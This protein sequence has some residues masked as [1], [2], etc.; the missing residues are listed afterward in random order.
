[1]TYQRTSGPFPLSAVKTDKDQ[2]TII[3]RQGN[4]Y[5]KTFDPSAALLI[6][7]APDLL[8]ACACALADLEG[9]IPAID[10]DGARK[11]P[12]WATI[13]EL[14]AVIAKATGQTP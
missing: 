1:M 5:A 7:A 11:H 8:T 14:T 4:H 6:T 10:P 3:T 9:I 12:G 13:A 2:I